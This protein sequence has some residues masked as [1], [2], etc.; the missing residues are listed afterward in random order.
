MVHLGDGEHSALHARVEECV[1][2]AVGAKAREAG[3]VLAIHVLEPA[4]DED[5]VIVQHLNGEDA[6]VRRGV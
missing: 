2:R 4:A 1:E 6:A 5:A 3:H